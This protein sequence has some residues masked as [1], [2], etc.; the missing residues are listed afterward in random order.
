MRTIQ[1]IAYAFTGM[2]L[3]S[4]TLWGCSGDQGKKEEKKTVTAQ[5]QMGKDA[6]QAVQKPRWKP[7]R[8]PKRKQEPPR[9]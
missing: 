8:Q 5:E 2:A 4:M 1:K 3:C 9:P 6:A 7:A